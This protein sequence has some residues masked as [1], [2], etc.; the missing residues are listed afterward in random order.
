MAIARRMPNEVKSIVFTLSKA[1]PQVRQQGFYVEHFPSRKA[2]G[3]NGGQ[4]NARF[5]ARLSAVIDEYRPAV[6]AFDGTLPYRGLRSLIEQQP[7]PAFV[8]IRRPMWQPD[9]D[10]E[11]LTYSGLFDRII[12]PGEFASPA[13]EG[14][15]VGRR[16]EAVCVDPIT[17]CDESELLPRQEAEAQLG[18]E[19]GRVHALIQLGELGAFER[20]FLMQA[21][22]TQI[23]RDSETQVAILESAISERFVVPSSVHKIAATY[24]IARLYS[25]FDFVISAAGYNSYHELVG[26]QIP[27]AF[28]PVRKLTDNQAARARYAEDVGVGVETG[29]KPAAAIELLLSEADRDRMKARALE[30]RFANGAVRAAD[31][32]VRLA[33]DRETTPPASRLA[34]RQK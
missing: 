23:L 26:F 17:F 12:E 6:I 8:W 27:T 31:E 22:V 32:I 9:A 30:L 33:R 7:G 34:R 19:P 24:P 2:S 1:L 16:D 18:L 3:L 5:A 28:Y 21:S 20:D 25:A 4:W 11:V 15:T 29:L 13:D 10:P 14:P